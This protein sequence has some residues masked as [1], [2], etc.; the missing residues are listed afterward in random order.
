MKS[1]CVK[2]SAR[3]IQNGANLLSALR[4]KKKFFVCRYLR[5]K[6]RQGL[7]SENANQH[8]D[9]NRKIMQQGLK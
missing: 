2:K 9:C 3:K 4:K 6:L 5:L 8:N 1:V 7:L